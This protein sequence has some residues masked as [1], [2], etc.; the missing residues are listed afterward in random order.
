MT[1]KQHSITKEVCF[2]GK[3]LQTGTNVHVKC[4]PADINSGIIFQRTDLPE[5]PLLRLQDALF[6]D[7]RERRS[8]IALGTFEVQT[9]E[10]FLAALWGLKIDNIKIEIDGIE[11]PAMDGSAK[12]FMDVL[13]TAGRV[14]QDAVQKIIKIQEQEKIEENGK[15]LTIVPYDGFY[16]SYYIDYKTASIGK[17]KFEI[18]LNPD[19]FENQIAPART[20]C[21]KEEAEALLRAGLGK[22]ADYQ[23]T[24]VL[25]DNGPIGTTMRFPNEPVRHKIL[26]LVGDFYML[27]YCIQGKVSAEKTGHS[28]NAK[29]L[30]LIY[31]KYVCTSE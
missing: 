13:K 8:T 15:S 7:T 25:E 23:N 20:F 21:L 31:E 30:K 24:L 1:G 9:V 29:M 16:V 18:D 3:T 11:L 27:G 19:S 22:G 2:S 12:G 26:D 28:L 17:E 14:E 10:H 5:N 6:S 4:K